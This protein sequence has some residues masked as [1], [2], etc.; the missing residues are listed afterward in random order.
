MIPAEK[1][2]IT[3]VHNPKVQFVRALLKDRSARAEHGLFVVEGIR[4]AEEALASGVIPRYIYY[5]GQ[6]SARGRELLA[7]FQA[8]GCETHEMLPDLL[9]RLSDTETTQGILLVVPLNPAP[10][11]GGADLVLIIDQVR[12]PGNMGTILRTAAGVGV[13]VVFVTPGSVDPYMP[14][15]VRA[16]MGA[17]F[18]LNLQQFDW[19][20]IRQFCSQNQPTPLMLLLAD[21]GGGSSM[22]R[23]DL[24]TPVALVVGSEADG[25]SDAARDYI[26]GLIHIPMP[27]KFESLNAGVAASIL[28]YEIVRQRSV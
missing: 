25:A 17:H 21:S 3:S 13:Q 11:P 18:R 22:W 16:G 14:K 12:D 24:T 2:P 10:L 27:G 9:D 7:D 20:D 8:T 5:S 4:L 6:L 1:T 28:L 15:V 19:P 26:D 23:T